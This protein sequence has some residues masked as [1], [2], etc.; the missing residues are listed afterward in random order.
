ML[1]TLTSERVP[2]DT[3][4]ACIIDHTLL[5]P[6]ATRQQI[7][8]LCDEATT[9]GFAT[10]CVNPSYVRMC[11]KKLNGSKVKVCT[12]IGF[13]LGATSSQAKAFEAAQAIQDGHW[14]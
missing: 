11:A 5:L 3:S 7:E 10:V 6:E 13:P 8:Q 4:L 2:F 14:K 1:H 12:V 9:Y